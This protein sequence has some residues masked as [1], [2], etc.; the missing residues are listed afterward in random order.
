MSRT[1]S[2]ILRRVLAALFLLT[3]LLVPLQALYACEMLDGAPPSTACCCG[4]EMTGGCAMG[5]G[6]SVPSTPSSSDCCNTSLEIP[7]SL[8]ATAPAAPS[9]AVAVPQAPQLPP[10]LPSPL[11]AVHPA[12]CGAIAIFPDAPA[13][14]FAG[15]RTYLV[16]QRFRN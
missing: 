15:T 3:S 12:A 2:P 16:T 11:L 5:G 14:W 6:C 1:C 9:Q 13:T 10:A 4:G 8:D 7:A